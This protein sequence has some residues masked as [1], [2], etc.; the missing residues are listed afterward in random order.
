MAFL[1]AQQ[2]QAVDGPLAVVCHALQD[3]FEVTDPT[4]DGGGV[5]EVAG[6]L[7]FADQFVAVFVQVEGE[8]E[9]CAVAFDLLGGEFELS[10]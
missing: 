4:R 8:V 6:V 7:E 2:R 9:L 3:L 5:E 10:Q 1:G